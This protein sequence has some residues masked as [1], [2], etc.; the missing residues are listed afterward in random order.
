MSASS[1]CFYVY[2][3]VWVEVGGAAGLLP[4]CS[5]RRASGG[6]VALTVMG[7]MPGR[8]MGVVTALGWNRGTDCAISMAV[9]PCCGKVEYIWIG[10]GAWPAAYVC[11]W[12]CDD[13][14]P[15][16]VAGIEGYDKLAGWN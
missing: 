1:F 10:A 16:S 2:W 13:W 12:Y 8:E 14:T 9:L 5:P 15:K 4:K 6:I 11:G 7:G 3:E